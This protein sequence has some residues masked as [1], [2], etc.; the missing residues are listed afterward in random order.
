[1]DGFVLAVDVFGAGVYSM[2]AG[3]SYAINTPR[4]PVSALIDCCGN[5]RVEF[6]R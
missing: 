3:S 4:L 2:L 1:M 6:G 5:E